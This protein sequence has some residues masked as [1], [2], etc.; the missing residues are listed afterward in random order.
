M[1]AL[2]AAEAAGDDA[3]AGNSLAFLAYL[4]WASGRSGITLAEA[5]C[6][7]AGR[8]ATPGVRALLW[9]RLAWQYATTGRVQETEQALGRAEEAI[10]EHAG[11]REPD[12]VYWVDS[13]EIAIMSGGCWAELRRPLRAITPLESALERYAD[14]HA[15]DKALYL[16]WLAEAYLD[17]GEAE[18]ASLITGQVLDLADGLASTRPLSRSRRLAE[19]LRPYRSIAS[20]GEVVG[21]VEAA[22]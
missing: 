14:T 5:A 21:R 3:L 8:H 6:D 18:H 16:S 12:W 1:T 13:D 22:G 17:A 10:A 7:R 19:R 4:E 2:A 11:Q 20:V 15:R 9:D